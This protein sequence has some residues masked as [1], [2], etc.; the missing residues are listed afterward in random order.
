[1]EWKNFPNDF[2]NQYQNI[3]SERPYETLLTGGYRGTMETE[4]K[5]HKYWVYFP[6]GMEYSCK[7]LVLLIPN[8]DSVDSF[9][10]RTGWIEISER[11]KLLLLMAGSSEDPWLTDEE[12]ASRLASLNQVRNDRTYMDTQRAFSYFAG[13]GEGAGHGHRFVAANPALYASAAF[14]GEIKMS[15]DELEKEGEKGTAASDIPKREVACPVCFVGQ[16]ELYP[17]YVIRYWRRACKTEEKA[18]RQDNMTVYLPDAAQ[19]GSAVDHQPVARVAWLDSEPFG[20]D[21]ARNVRDNFLS[22][23]VRATGILND[24]LHPYRTEEQW[25]IRRKEIEIDGFKRHWYEY[26]PE[27]LAVLADKKIPVV[28]FFHGGSASALSGLYSHEWVQVAKERGF[29]LAMPTGTMRKQEAFMPHP[30]WNAA[31]LSDHM[32]DEKLIRH[33]IADIQSRYPVDPSRIYACGHSMGAAMAQRAALA[34][35]DLF[36]AAAS[37][38]GVVTGGFMGDF[39][40]PGVRT[41]IP[42]PIWIQM[43]EKDVGGGTLLNNSNAARTVHYWVTRYQLPDE[44]APACWRTGR[45]LN[46]EWRTEGGV[47]MVRYTTTLEKPHAITPQDPWFYYD[48][49][50]CCFSKGEEGELYYKGKLVTDG[51]GNKL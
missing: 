26:V 20:Q 38:S 2:I 48:E 45:Y 16:R 8:S 32:N 50:F 43:G 3:S 44:E 30:A 37:N 42:V 46:R 21:T 33:M 5:I 23:T 28:V 6:E 31:R 25:G 36:T 49:F 14:F 7:H 39:D 12:A 19:H 4:S 47:P 35:S 24:D 22:K 15:Q 29:I 41:D 27:R 9:L 1:M 34:M 17:E 13:Y 40:T 18:Y 10:E 51:N 11:E